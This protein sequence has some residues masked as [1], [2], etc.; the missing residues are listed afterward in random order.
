MHLRTQM[1]LTSLMAAAL[2]SLPARAQ[3]RLSCQSDIVQPSCAVHSGPWDPAD[4]LHISASCQ[5]CTGGGSDIQCSPAEKVTPD[6]LGVETLTGDGVSGSFSQVGVCDFGLLLLEFSGTLAPGTEY[7]V[8]IEVPGLEKM[9]L[10]R[11]TTSGGSNPLADGGGTPPTSDTGGTEPSSDG[12]DPITGDSASNGGSGGDPSGEDDGCSCSLGRAP[13]PAAG[14]GAA[15]VFLIAV[16][17]LRR[18][19]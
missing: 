14:G 15:F 8:T 1:M 10:L 4:S 16:A 11:F 18:R 12:G 3:T 5:E 13:A 6:V 9:E 2:I 19:R 17:L 7:R